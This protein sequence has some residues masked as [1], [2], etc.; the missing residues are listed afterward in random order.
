MRNTEEIPGISAMCDRVCGSCFYYYQ[1]SCSPSG[2]LCSTSHRLR[3]IL[4]YELANNSQNR[5]QYNCSYPDAGYPD[6]LGPSGN[7]VE[8]PTELICLEITG[9][10][11]DIS[12]TSSSKSASQTFSYRNCTTSFLWLKYF[13]QLSN[14]YKEL[15]I[16]ILFVRK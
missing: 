1:I 14:T 4:S 8:N 7:F 9:N 12:L 11:I 6:R 2:T 5:L 15:C 10:R 16:N 13:P 3:D